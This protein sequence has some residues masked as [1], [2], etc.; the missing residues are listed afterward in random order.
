MPRLSKRLSFI[1]ASTE[2]SSGLSRMLHGGAVQREKFRIVLV[3]FRGIITP[4]LH[5]SSV[6]C[7]AAPSSEF[8]LKSVSGSVKWAW[9]QV[10]D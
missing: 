2:L 6:G 5:H 9:P 3:D 1:Q 10:V 8:A 4:S 7:A